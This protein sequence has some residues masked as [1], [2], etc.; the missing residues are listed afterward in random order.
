MASAPNRPINLYF[1][2]P[3][4]ARGEHLIGEKAVDDDGRPNM[5][6]VKR[7]EKRRVSFAEARD[8]IIA[9]QAIDWDNSTPVQKAEAEA[10]VKERNAADEA[11][12]KKAAE[13]R[14]Q[15]LT[16]A[17]QVEALTKEVARLTKKAA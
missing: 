16:L 6:T 5:I 14:G 2:A 9:K 13:D 7:G 11:A 1:T 17:Q 8:L 3:I 12:A 4:Y 10:H 15:Q